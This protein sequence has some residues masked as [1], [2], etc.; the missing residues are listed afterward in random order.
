LGLQLLY[1]NA[2]VVVCALGIAEEEREIWSPPRN[3]YKGHCPF[4]YL[5]IVPRSS[6]IEEPSESGR[7]HE[8]AVFYFFIGNLHMNE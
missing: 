4:D 3:R 1:N 7:L 2:E 6:I 8:I 5:H